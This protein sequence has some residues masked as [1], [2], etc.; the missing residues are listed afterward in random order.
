MNMIKC[1]LQISNGAAQRGQT[2]GAVL[3]V[4]RSA[5]EHNP[6][7]TSKQHSTTARWIRLGVNIGGRQVLSPLGQPNHQ[8]SIVTL[9][10]YKVEEQAKTEKLKRS[11][12]CLSNTYV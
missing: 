3:P 2:E 5:P 7:M 12:K 9:L 1:A 8:T 6:Y 10:F 4:R 11:C